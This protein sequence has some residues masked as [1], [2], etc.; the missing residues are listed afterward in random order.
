MLH[1]TKIG[2]NDIVK[3]LP[4]V[5]E[6]FYTSPDLRTCKKCGTVME[7]PKKLS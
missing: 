1:E 4:V 3:D 7:P 5:M 6:A 2:V